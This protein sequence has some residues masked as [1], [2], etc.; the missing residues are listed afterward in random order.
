MDV[1]RMNSPPRKRI[2]VKS[3][4]EAQYYTSRLPWA[5]IRIASQSYRLPAISEENLLG[6]L[7]LA[8]ADVRFPEAASSLDFFTAEHAATILDFVDD[9]WWQIDALMVHCEAGTSRSPAI[10]AAISRI[11]YGDDGEFLLP[12]LYQPNMHVYGQML[13]TAERKGLMRRSHQE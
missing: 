2:H 6:I 12:H 7:Q 3:A 5:C 9:L 10:A 1:H 8:F 13:E 11:Y 4:I